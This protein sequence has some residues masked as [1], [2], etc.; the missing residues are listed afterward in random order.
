MIG[1]AVVFSMLRC[2]FRVNRHPAYRIVDRS[3]TIFRAAP[4]AV[5]RLGGLMV[6]LDRKLYD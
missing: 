1:M 2:L 4:A 3:S 6:R 5:R